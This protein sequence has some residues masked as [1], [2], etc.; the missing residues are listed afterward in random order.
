MALQAKGKGKEMRKKKE[1]S[2]KEC[3]NCKKKGHLSKDCWAKGEGMEGKGPKGRK[4]P[5]KERANQAEEVN[6]SLNNLS[7]MVYGLL[8]E[9]L[10]IED[11]NSLN[12]I[13]FEISNGHINLGDILFM[14][15]FQI[16]PS[17]S[18][19]YINS[20][21]TSHISNNCNIYSEFFPIKATP[22]Q[23]IRTLATALSYGMAEIIFKVKGKAITH[24]LKNI[25]YILEAPNCLLSVSC[26]NRMDG[27]IIFHQKQCFLEGKGGDIIGYRQMHGRLYLLNTKM[28]N[29]KNFPTMLHNPNYL[30][31]NGTDSLDIYQSLPWNVQTKKT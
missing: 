5:N 18:N 11:K 17:K 30:E 12:N 9:M 4:G 15:N 28:N 20:R 31:I 10:F 26:F 6:S 1:N 13:P 16:P 2:D 21:T 14:T 29:Q 23:G 27:R 24:K 22:V 19:W 3:Y 7:Y 8:D 25:L